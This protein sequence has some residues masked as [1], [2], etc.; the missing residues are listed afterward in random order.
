[1]A[2]KVKHT[3]KRQKTTGQSSSQGSIV[4]CF[5]NEAAKKRFDKKFATRMVKKTQVIDYKFF[6]KCNFSFI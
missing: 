1:M 2:S 3:V 6:S 5:Q 4:A